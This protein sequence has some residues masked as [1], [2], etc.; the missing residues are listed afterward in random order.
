MRTF[1]PND[2]A[3]LLRVSHSTV[4]RWIREDKLEASKFG[5][6][7]IISEDALVQFTAEHPRYS[8]T[9]LDVDPLTVMLEILYEKIN[10][11][12]KSDVL[13][14]YFEKGETNE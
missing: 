7:W 14:I 2:I 5:R 9:R 12:I 1:R 3:L 6:E 13:K 11:V 8:Y 10:D 4:C